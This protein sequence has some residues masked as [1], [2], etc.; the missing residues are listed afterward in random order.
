M[1]PRRL[2]L[3]QKAVRRITGNDDRPIAAALDCSRVCGKVKPFGSR[4][5]F[6]MAACA[7][8][9]EK[10]ANIVFVGWVTC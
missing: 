2:D 4:I 10:D 8:D 3:N 9:G 6:D 1:I 5:T 7:I